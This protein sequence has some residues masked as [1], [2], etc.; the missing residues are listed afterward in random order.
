MTNA[1]I[2]LQSQYELCS[3]YI[4]LPLWNY[5]NLLI[6]GFKKLFY[7]FILAQ[8]LAER[9]KQEKLNIRCVPTSFQARQ[10]IIHHKLP[11]T[12]LEIDPIVDITIDGA[13]EVDANLTCIKGGGA[14]LLQEKIVASNS[15]KLVIIADHTK[16]SEKLGEKWKK[17]RFVG[18]YVKSYINC[19]VIDLDLNK[20]NYNYI[21]PSFLKL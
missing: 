19:E 15:K 14:C 16:D 10:L 9:F 18:C 21:S 20:I 17:G 6:S 7:Y 11:L 2:F 13:D 8:R 1:Y 4:N 3:L 5:L 12:D